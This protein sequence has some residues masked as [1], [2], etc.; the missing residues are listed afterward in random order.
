MSIIPGLIIIFVA[1]LIKI[2]TKYRT[3]M[4]R[5]LE[6]QSETMEPARLKAPKEIT[7]KNTLEETQKR[8]RI[9]KRNQ[10]RTKEGVSRMMPKEAQTT[11]SDK[12]QVA[13][14][15]QKQ[16]KR[17][18]LNPAENKKIEI[19]NLDSVSEASV[20][21]QALKAALILSEPRSRRPII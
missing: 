1:I 20:D 5:W 11:Q 14:L 15:E 9:A 16:S 8:Q 12:E 7:P 2:S 10:P 17:A 21:R 3:Q 19:T 6:S 18:R 13:E 4:K